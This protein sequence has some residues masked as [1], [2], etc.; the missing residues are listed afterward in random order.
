MGAGDELL[1]RGGSGANLFFMNGYLRLLTP[2]ILDETHHEGC[3]RLSKEN[4]F[5]KREEGIG[6]PR[7][8]WHVSIKLRD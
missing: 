7:H 2:G 6:R 8:P 1:S 3:R 4:A 5:M